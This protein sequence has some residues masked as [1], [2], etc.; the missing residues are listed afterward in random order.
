MNGTDLP[1]IRAL[2]GH[3]D[4]KTTMRY[5]H[6][7]P[8]HRHRAVHKLCIGYRIDWI[9]VLIRLFLI[10]DSIRLAA[11]HSVGDIRAVMALGINSG[12]SDVQE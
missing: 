1:S 8:E 12:R 10:L 2:M 4:I 7:A 6:V 5:S 3:A 9:E 11:V